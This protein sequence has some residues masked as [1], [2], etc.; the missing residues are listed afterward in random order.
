MTAPSAPAKTDGIIWR[1]RLL[2]AR[3]HKFQAFLYFCAIQD[4]RGGSERLPW[5]P[6]DSRL[7]QGALRL[8]QWAYLKERASAWAGGNSE[9][10]LKARQLGFTW[11]AAAYALHTAMQPGARVLVISKG[12]RDAHAFIERMDF[13]WARLP[14]SLRS[15]KHIDNL[16]HKVYSGGG[17][18]LAL[19]STRDAGRG[20]TGSLLIFDENAFH[21]WAAQNWTA[22]R[23][24]VADVGQTLVMSTANGATGHFHDLYRQAEGWERELAAM[25]RELEQLLD[26]GRDEE[27]ERLERAMAYLARAALTP[28]FVGALARPDRSPEWLAAEKRVYVGMPDEFGSEYPLTVAEAFVQLRGLVYPQFDP[29]RHVRDTHP[30]PWEE[31][32][33]RI[34]C[35]DLGGGDPTA[36]VFLG[37]YRRPGDVWRVHQ[38]GEYYKREVLTAEKAAAILEQ[39]N[40]RG[41]IHLVE[42]DPREPTLMA[43][44]DKV[45]GFPAELGNWNREEGLGIVAHWLTEGT[46]TIAAECEDSIHEFQGYRWLTRMD[47]HDKE[48]YA[49]GRAVDNHADA[50]DARRLGMVRLHYLLLSEGDLQEQYQDIRL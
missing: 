24:T 15:R 22:A 20:F 45:Y 10:I 27:A 29:D 41:Q 4:V 38:Y 3:A 16:G 5:L 39:W 9:V 23:A 37:A 48:R 1:A 32:T 13:I 50:M 46:L 17:E 26:A 36:I 12:M 30:V 19:P 25:R 18:V 2:E 35:Y 8:K 21:M 44:L 6:A 34:A 11:L 49:T 33:Y 42:C 7:Q 40:R 43:T 47:P 14:D 31:C 28:V